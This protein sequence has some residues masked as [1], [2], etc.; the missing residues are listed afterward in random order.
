MVLGVWRKHLAIVYIALSEL[1]REHLGRLC[2]KYL[3]TK[4]ILCV[5][6][7]FSCTALQTSIQ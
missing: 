3:A 7:N 6:C 5:M 2:K 4:L 1:H